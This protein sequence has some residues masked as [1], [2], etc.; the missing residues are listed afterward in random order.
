MILLIA[1]CLVVPV[2]IAFEEEE[3][4]SWL[5]IY[6][7]TDVLFFI[8]LILNFFTSYTD[9]THMREITDHKKIA[10]KYVYSWFFLDLFS[11][12]PIDFFV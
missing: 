3:S 4:G 8:D 6:A 7:L 2:R 12:I 9:E 1:V 11:I 10:K 5:V